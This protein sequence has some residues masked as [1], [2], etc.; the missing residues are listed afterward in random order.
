MADYIN[1]LS[2]DQDN[3]NP[4]I[5]ALNPKVVAFG[6]SY[7]GMLSAMIRYKYP[8]KIAGAIAGSAPMA[9]TSISDHHPSDFN[10]VTTETYK[11]YNHCDDKI[12]KIWPTI[13]TMSDEEILSKFNICDDQ[14]GYVKNRFIAGLESSYILMAMA[15]YDHA[16]N[17]I[18]PLPEWPIEFYCQNLEKYTNDEYESFHVIE[19]IIQLTRNFTGQAVDCLPMDVDLDQPAKLPGNLHL[20]KVSAS[21][22]PV[23]GIDINSWAFQTCTQIPIVL[24]S[25]KS[26]MFRNSTFDTVE[27]EFADTKKQMTQN[28]QDQFGVTPDYDYIKNTYGYFQDGSHFSNIVFTNG[29]FDPWRSGKPLIET[30]P[31]KDII[32]INIEKGAHHAEMMPVDKNDPISFYKARSKIEQMV[33]KWIQN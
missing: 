6:G 4:K 25:S 28:C 30:N 23:K 2:H 19:N 22:Q 3:D 18:M 16:A 29:Q 31:D 10:S 33:N 14:Q 8:H 12:R 1:I 27:A 15:N 21:N 9:I 26:D 11:F 7:G 24:V 13:D 5:A 17:F 32:M 20:Q